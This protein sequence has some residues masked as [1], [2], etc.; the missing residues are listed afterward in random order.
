MYAMRSYNV[1]LKVSLSLSLS[2]KLYFWK[3]HDVLCVMKLKTTFLAILIIS[4]VFLLFKRTN[5]W[6]TEERLFKSGEEVCPLNA[7]VM[8]G[9][10]VMF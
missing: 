8:I 10:K 3:T 2:L 7:K 4:R 5:D 6:L 1:S 9:V